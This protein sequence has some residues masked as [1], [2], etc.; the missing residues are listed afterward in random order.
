MAACDVA[1]PDLPPDKPAPP[2]AVTRAKAIET[3]AL[4]PTPLAGDAT[5]TTIHRL[6]NGMTVYLSP[7]PQEPSVVAHVV[8]RAGS[9]NDSEQSAG[10]AHYLEHMLFKGIYRRYAP[11]SGMPPRC[12]T[13]LLG[14]RGCAHR[15]VATRR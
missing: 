14:L 6:S 13:A 2:P 8:V 10:L 7:D 12:R 1:T 15:A 3:P 5:K 9:R 4:V 11:C